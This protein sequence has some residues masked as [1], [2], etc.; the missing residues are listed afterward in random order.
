[1]LALAESFLSEL[2]QVVGR[3]AAGI[4][5]DAREVLLGYS[6]PGNVR[7]LRNVLERATILCDGGL[8]TADHL[9]RE[10]G[11]R[12]GA[13]AAAKPSAPGAGST[14]NLDAVE[15]DAIIRA[16][17]LSGNNR[18]QAARLLGIA[19]PQLYHRLK[20]YGIDSAGAAPS[21]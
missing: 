10:L 14:V 18:S 11:Q 6:W 12:N 21:A 20:K 9:P 5:R 16:L 8:I 4:S 2:G 7:E 3:P 17:E 13:S 19:R 1:V 15:R